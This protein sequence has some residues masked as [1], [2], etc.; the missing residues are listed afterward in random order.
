MI[1]NCIK[2]KLN[3]MKD[4]ALFIDKCSLFDVD[5]DYK[6]DKYVIDAKSL[7][8]ILS[9]SLGREAIVTINTDD[10]RMIDTFIDEL[11]LWIVEE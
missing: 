4:V 5:I 3:S 11:K 8:G 6:V 10:K 9:I 1:K 7:M 2:I